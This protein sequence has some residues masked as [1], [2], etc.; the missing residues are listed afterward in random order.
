MRYIVYWC[1][2]EC[3]A[4]WKHIA[5]NLGQS[6]PQARLG[7]KEYIDQ[8]EE[9]S[10]LEESLKIWN[11]IVKKYKLQGDSKIL[12]WPSQTPRFRPGEINNTFVWWKEKRITAVCTVIEGKTFKMF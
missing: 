6:Q 9:N 8:N 12:I 4:R 10:I 7:E 2:L 1:S 3:E 11:E 5:L